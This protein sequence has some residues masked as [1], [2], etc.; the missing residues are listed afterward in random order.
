MCRRRSCRVANRM[1]ARFLASQR[2]RLKPNCSKRSRQRE[3]GRRASAEAV[4]AGLERITIGETS[5]TIRWRETPDGPPRNLSIPW[6]PTPS[7]RRRQILQ[8]EGKLASDLQPMR[9]EARRAFTAAYAKARAWLD[10]LADDPATSIEELAKS[11]GR[12]DRSIRQTLSFAFLD[13][14]LVEAALEGRL[15]RGFGLKRLMDLPPAWPEQWVLL[16]L[17]DSIRS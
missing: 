8:G 12:T 3:P 9:M 5:L 10:R 14:A 16:G 6:S 7:R 15:P 4:R 2:R 1:R 13:P 11:E 17:E